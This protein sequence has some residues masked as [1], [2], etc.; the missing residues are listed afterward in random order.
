MPHSLFFTSGIHRTNSDT[1][2]YVKVNESYR[3]SARYQSVIFMVLKYIAA[4]TINVQIYFEVF[5]ELEEGVVRE[6]THGLPALKG[7]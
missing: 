6:V 5:N 7:A 1:I 4:Q 2:K 3:H